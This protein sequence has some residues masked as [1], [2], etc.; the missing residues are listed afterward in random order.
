MIMIFLSIKVTTPL[1]KWPTK[2]RL[3]KPNTLFFFFSPFFGEE[4]QFE[5]PRKFRYL[6]VYVYD[7]DKTEKVIGKVALKREHLTSYN[8]RDQWFPLKNVDS[9]SEVQGKC[10]IDIKFENNPD[11]AG[12]DKVTVRFVQLF[13]YTKII[14]QI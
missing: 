1:N 11:N 6:S 3:Y 2:E 10:Q 9:N 7:R 12:D 8:N 4:F 5:I 13:N 14:I